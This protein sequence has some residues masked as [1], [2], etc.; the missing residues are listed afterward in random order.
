MKDGTIDR[1]TERE[2]TPFLERCE[3]TAGLAEEVFYF[4][5][6]A[7]KGEFFP[8]GSDMSVRF[9][10]LMGIVLGTL[11]KTNEGNT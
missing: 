6:L 10:L 7:T 11:W 1:T 5:E 2:K 8:H 4:H 3:T 9:S